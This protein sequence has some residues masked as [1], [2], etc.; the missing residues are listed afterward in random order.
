MLG[1]LPLEVLR[2]CA[3]AASF[4]DGKA[5]VVAAVTLAMKTKEPRRVA[6]P[7]RETNLENFALMIGNLDS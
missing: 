2:S 3:F 1:R 4:R 5:I 7:A 6:L